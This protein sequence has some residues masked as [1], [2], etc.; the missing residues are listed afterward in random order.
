VRIGNL[1][2]IQESCKCLYQRCEIYDELC[3]VTVYRGAKAGSWYI[4]LLREVLSFDLVSFVVK[5]E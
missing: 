5:P 3:R 2:L 4:P 1:P